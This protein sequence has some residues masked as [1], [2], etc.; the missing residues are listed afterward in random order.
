MEIEQLTVKSDARTSVSPLRRLSV[1]LGLLANLRRH[2]WRAAASFIRRMYPDTAWPVAISRFV[3]WA[4]RRM[5]MQIPEALVHIKCHE[6]ISSTP[7]WLASPNPFANYPWQQD[8]SVTLP[9]EVEVVAI[10]AGFTGG[11]LAYHWSKKAPS[12]KVMAVLE[13]DVP[14]YGASGRNSGVSNMGRHLQMLQN[15]IRNSLCSVRKDLTDADREKLSLQFAVAYVKGSYR[16]ADLVEQTVREEAF[17][18]N[19][20]R[21]GK[22]ESIAPGH[23]D[24]LKQAVKIGEETGYDDWKMLTPQTVKQKAGANTDSECMSSLKS[25]S[26]HPAKWV[27]SLFQVALKQDQVK[28]YTQTKVEKVEDAGDIYLVHTSRGT[29]R[30]RHVVNATEAYTPLLHEQFENVIVPM[31]TQAAFVEKSP[32]DMKADA[33]FSTGQA[34]LHQVEQ[35][36]LIGTDLTR[37]PK[38]RIRHGQPS[39]FITL[40]CLVEIGRFFKMPKSKVSREWAGPVGYTRDEFPIVGLI[41]GKRQFIIGGMCGSGSAVA[42]NGSRCIC[43]R[44]LGIETE[45]DDYPSAY[46]APSRVLDPEGHQWPEV[47]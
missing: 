27:W 26:F 3:V 23:Y 12:D 29:I 40:H 2:D 22:I 16:N 14:A 4:L 8:S 17:D 20:K 36:V 24:Q 44:I 10:G 43:N 37:I 35:G 5:L 47:E 33:I 6:P 34:F 7:V 32:P 18:C 11:A 1:A 42:F 30:A 46:F 39:R 13:M 41:D 21:E 15:S 28:L 38:H 19:Y 9:H 45:P 31:Q 25:A